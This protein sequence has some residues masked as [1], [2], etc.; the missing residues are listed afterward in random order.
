MPEGRL[1]NLPL[2]FY[3]PS[4]YYT[5]T[6][7]THNKTTTPS[8]YSKEEVQQNILVPDT[9]TTLAETTA[10]CW[11]CWPAHTKDTICH[12]YPQYLQLHK[13]LPAIST[14]TTGHI[15]HH[16]P[17]GPLST[18]FIETTLAANEE[19]MADT[20]GCLCLLFKSFL[21]FTIY[22]VYQI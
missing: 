21:G 9:N 5:T 7:L 3:T 1:G 19:L 8:F 13:R 2:P 20:I 4:V 15:S 11:T 12:K 16:D 18:L 17:I 14:I 6:T 10:T 22:N